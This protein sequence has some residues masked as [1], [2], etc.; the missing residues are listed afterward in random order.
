MPKAPSP[1][2]NPGRRGGTFRKR[3]PSPAP[4]PADTFGWV[5]EIP[6]DWTVSDY[7]IFFLYRPFDQDPRLDHPHEG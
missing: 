6:E 2:K 5:S 1:K 3:S 4:E 7:C